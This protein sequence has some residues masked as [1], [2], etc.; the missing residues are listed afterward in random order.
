[1]AMGRV[2]CAGPLFNRREQAEMRAISRRLKDAGFETY[3]PHEDGLEFASVVGIVTRQI[4]SSSAAN[5][6]VSR[7][8]F[9]L[10]VY[11]LLEWSDAIVA[12]MNGR[13]PDEG[14]VAE[15][16]LAWRSRKAVVL[17]KDDVRSLVNGIDNSMWSGLGEFRIVHQVEEIPKS[18]EIAMRNR[19]P[20]DKRIENTAAEGKQIA[21][22]LDSL[23]ESSTK[24]EEL[25]RF[26][27]HLFK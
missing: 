14:T 12:N 24:N 6:V 11:K 23:R 4:H 7:A 1:M 25:A 19:T 2:Y 16:A 18:I 9:A 20:V 22:E 3:L 27:V 5:L 15:A 10:D 26:L 21:G 8:I 17:Y 13:V